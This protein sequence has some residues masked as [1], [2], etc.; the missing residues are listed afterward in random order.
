V[1]AA[2]PNELV[3]RFAGRQEENRMEAVGNK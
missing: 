1:L 3:E 2:Q